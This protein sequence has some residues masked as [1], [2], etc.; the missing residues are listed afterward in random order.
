MRTKRACAAT[1][2]SVAVLL[3]ASVA[4]A[5]TIYPPSGGGSGGS[6]SNPFLAPAANNCNAIPYSFTGD[7]NTGMCTAAADTLQLWTA[8]AVRLQ[9]NATALTGAV[10]FLAPDG[11]AALPSF[12]FSV[13][14]G[15]GF[16]WAS[17]IGLTAGDTLR[18]QLGQSIK[19]AQTSWLEWTASAATAAAD[20]G[21]GSGSALGAADTVVVYAGGL[22]VADAP[23]QFRTTGN[24]ASYREQGISTELLTL[25]VGGTTTDTAANLLPA[26]SLIEAVVTRV[27]TAITGAGVTSFSVGDATIGGRFS[28]L[29]ALALGSTSIGTLHQDA[30][31]TSGPRQTAAAKVRITAVGATPTGGIV[32]II[33]YYSTYTI[34]GT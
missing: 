21:I 10:P 28:T 17:G 1:L 29:N 13:L 27:T 33:V 26:G 25:S 2:L 3:L 24:N 12:G 23:V 4:G 11:T 9:G 5:Q 31:G 18:W 6:F 22:G 19:G 16:Y 20:V 14:G 30:T 8:G 34:P 15:Y 7:S 32:R